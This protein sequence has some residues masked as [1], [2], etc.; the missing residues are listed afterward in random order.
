MPQELPCSSRLTQCNCHVRS[1]ATYWQ[2]QH[3]HRSLQQQLQ[4]PG[5]FTAACGVREC[6]PIM[7]ACLPD[8]GPHLHHTSCRFVAVQHSTSV[9]SAVS[10]RKSVVRTLRDA[11]LACLP[12]SKRRRAADR[13]CCGAHRE[14]CTGA[15][16]TKPLPP[17]LQ[18]LAPLLQPCLPLRRS[19]PALPLSP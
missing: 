12:G 6:A 3:T 13:A 10:V 4:Q 15:A 19:A 17:R 16:Y 1:R 9:H 11:L 18:L 14:H 2:Q 8:R 7:H 5:A